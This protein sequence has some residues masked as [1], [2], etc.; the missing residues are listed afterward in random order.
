M[1]DLI[2]YYTEYQNISCE[3]QNSEDIKQTAPILLSLID[4]YENRARSNVAE[5]LRNFKHSIGQKLQCFNNRDQHD[6]A[7][8]LTLL[9]ESVKEELDLMH[10][11]SEDMPRNP[12]D[13]N[14]RFELLLEDACEPCLVYKRQSQ[15][16]ISLH[17]SL[18]SDRNIQSA[19]LQ[20]LQCETLESKCEKCHGNLVLNKYFNDLPKI[21]CLQVQRYS[22]T[23][24]K[25]EMGITAPT[26]LFLPKKFLHKQEYLV[27]PIS[28]PYKKRFA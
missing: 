8:L 26:F 20:W 28:T 19:F 9:L 18:T 7:E 3:S 5:W 4:L 6:A 25:D 24:V 21:L 22:E 14:F 10:M 17:L 23:G 16:S 13:R 27:S 1:E 2:K 15:K 11:K 12:I